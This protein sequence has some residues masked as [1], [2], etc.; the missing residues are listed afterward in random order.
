MS[1]FSTAQL[2]LIHTTDPGTFCV[3]HWDTSEIYSS[4]QKRQAGVILLPPQRVRIQIPKL[5]VRPSVEKVDR[6]VCDVNN[7]M[8]ISGN[9]YT[10]IN[11]D[12]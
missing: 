2:K 12:V 6:N 8:S 1:V 5:S 9:Y 7:E 11:S 3:L 10:K 4:L